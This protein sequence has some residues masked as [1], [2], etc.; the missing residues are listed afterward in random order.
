M[1][2]NDRDEAPLPNTYTP[3]HKKRADN[4]LRAVF[5]VRLRWCKWLD[6]GCN[7]TILEEKVHFANVGMQI[8]L[9]R[10]TSVDSATNQSNDRHSL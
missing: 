9:D 5:L 2:P 3:P 10:A 4:R 8:S 1:V 7:R 6:L